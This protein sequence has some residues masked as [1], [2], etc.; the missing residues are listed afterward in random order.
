[1]ENPD[2]LYPVGSLCAATRVA[3]ARTGLALCVVLAAFGCAGPIA[4]SR[5]PAAHS[6]TPH[7]ER[8][9]PQTGEQITIGVDHVVERGQTVWRIAQ[10]YGVEVDVLARA[11]RLDDPT[12]L[13]TGQVL[14]IPGA[15]V[16]LQI[17]AYPSPADVVGAP[18]A[19]SAA[20]GSGAGPWLWPLPEPRVL[21]GFG[22]ARRSR[23]H[24]GIDLR[25]APGHPVV[26]SRAGHVVYSGSGMNGYGKT[27]IVDHGDGTSSLYAHNSRLLVSDGQYVERGQAIAQI[28]RSGNATTEHCHFEIRHEGRPVDPLVYL[29]PAREARR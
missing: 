20:E 5:I 16:V 13:D 15:V 17:P 7:S 23:R 9:V 6:A 28:G 8:P 29:E 25:G 19:G 24:E 11:N 2:F 4:G 26:A 14:F 27:V 12:K 10:A 18:A 3:L 22:V 1:M 21:S